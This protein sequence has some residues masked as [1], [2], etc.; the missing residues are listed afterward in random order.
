MSILD[1]MIHAIKVILN[2][3]ANTKFI[4]LKKEKESNDNGKP[5]V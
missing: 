2:I 4:N 5:S 1:E 3:S